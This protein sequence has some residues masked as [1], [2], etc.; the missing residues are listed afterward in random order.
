MSSFTMRYQRKRAPKVRDTS[1]VG[2]V[3]LSSGHHHSL[4]TLVT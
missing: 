1:L 3:I 2:A 4:P